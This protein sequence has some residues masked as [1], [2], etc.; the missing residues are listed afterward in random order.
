MLG[1]PHMSNQPI[2]AAGKYLDFIMQ[3]ILL[4]NVTQ[5]FSQR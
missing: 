4:F 5:I 3:I 2:K 1:S